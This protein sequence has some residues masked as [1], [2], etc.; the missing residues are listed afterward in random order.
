ML[1]DSVRFEDR[2]ELQPRERRLLVEGTPAVLG[3]RAFDVLLVLVERAGQLV[4]KNDL[5]E[6]VWTGRVVEEGNLAVQVSSLRKV[7]SGE[8]IATIPGRGY[9]FTGCTSPSGSA[10]SGRD[11]P[12]LATV[13]AP[14]ATP[15]PAH[16]NAPA[17]TLVGRDADLDHLR[18]AL[19]TPGCVTLIGP[20][21]VGKTSL[22]RAAAAD[23]PAGAVWV[24]LA[25]LAEVPQVMVALALA[26]GLPPPEAGNAVAVLLRALGERLLVL[27]NAEHLVDA[28]ADLVAQLTRMQPA[29]ALLVTCQLPLSAPHERV[30]RVEPLA[31]GDD[32]QAGALA[33]FVERARAAD[34]R[35]A[36]ATGQLPLLQAICRQLDGLPL[37]LEMAAARVPALGL[38]GLHEALEQR[39]AVL[40]RGARTAAQRHRTLQAALD[41]SYGLLPPEEQRLFRAL[42][43]FAGGFTLDLAVAVTVAVTVAGDARHERWALI[44]TLASLIDRSLV[45]A[46]TGDDLNGAPRYRL[47]ETQRAYAI[48]RLGEAGELPA[49]RLRHAQAMLDVFETAR[50]AVSNQRHFRALAIAEHDN[51]REAIA[52]ATQHAPVIAVR[53]AASVCVTATFT[54]WRLEALRWLEASEA[55]LAHESVDPVSLARWWTER[56]RQLLMSER[57][58]AAAMAERARGYC[59]A[60]GDARA[61]FLVDS[62]LVRAQGVPGDLLATVIHELQ[63]LHEAHPEWQPRST[64][65][66][67][68]ALAIACARR[69]DLEGKLR[70]GLAELEAA[71]AFGPG[72]NADAAETNV[73]GTLNLM[74]RHDEALA[75]SQALIARA[76]NE[77]SGNLPW[78][79]STH[80]N[81]LVGLGRHAEVRACARQV[82]A[83]LQRYERPLLAGKW[84][85]MLSA[86]GRH[87]DAARI[88]GFMLQTCEAR[89]I[90]AIGETRQLLDT[91]EALSRAALGSERW[92]RHV[93]EG[94]SF[95]ETRA[96]ACLGVPL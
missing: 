28:V 38:K 64:L 2:Y 14:G 76:G 5:L 47:L 15:P 43:V 36:P 81:A 1:T 96:F 66:M 62:T 89:N 84:T 91:A 25:P 7:L 50:A 8:L 24:D 52:W 82:W 78:I 12:S 68:G 56:S 10:G 77:D 57:P 29:L 69:N 44:D 23:W 85:E 22:A 60:G 45:T 93:D 21:G 13:I 26:L 86:E 3:A 27:D 58:E 83:L 92:L 33:L 37:A 49:L 59:L 79:W 40:T 72:A 70:H 19:A 71:R 6:R 55:A 9:R 75:R 42:G 63:A 11:D 54:A 35:F 4:S 20:A 41:W 95:D 80:V 65:L 39:F 61:L 74:N 34:H 73:I 90:P 30:Q 94:R 48:E 88:T 67:H 16:P 53:L 17:A 32:L 46:D 31:L 18:T 51:A 87:E